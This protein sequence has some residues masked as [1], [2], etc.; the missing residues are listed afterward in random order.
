M[1]DF[2]LKK[3]YTFFADLGMNSYGN[4][5]STDNFK[6]INFYSDPDQ[7]SINITKKQLH[8]IKHYYEE[9]ILHDKFPNIVWELHKDKFIHKII[10]N[11]KNKILYILL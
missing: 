5:I 7:E 8:L 10:Y 9:N 2:K 3:S 11:P 4:I 6:K 1:N